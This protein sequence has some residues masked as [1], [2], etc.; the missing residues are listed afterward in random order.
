MKGHAQVTYIGRVRSGLKK[1]KDCPCQGKEGAPSARI[2]IFPEFK[3]GLKGIKTG[4]RL[5]LLT[6]F[7][8]ADREILQVHPRDN[9][10]YPLTGVFFTRSPNRPN[11]A[12]FPLQRKP[13][14][15]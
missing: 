6:W 5:V 15:V 2:E 13:C 7:H 3:E 8:K 10:N 11:L 12:I 1:L 14:P 9:P 4:T